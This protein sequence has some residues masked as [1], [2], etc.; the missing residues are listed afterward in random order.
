MRHAAVAAIA[1]IALTSP[2]LAAETPVTSAIEQVTVYPDG[3]SVTRI[4]R[5]DLAAGDNTLLARD[6]PPTLDPASVR[7]E[8]QGGARIVIGAVE[9]R[10]PRSDRPATNPEI[11]R[12][13]EALRD[14]RGV[15]DDGIAAAHAR[16]KFA[17]RFADAVPAGL[18]E[19][20]EARP[21]SEWRAAFAAVADEVAGADAIVREARL[22]QRTLDR[23]I[24]RLEAER[25]ANPPRKMEVRIDLASEAAAAAT[26]RVTYAVRGARWNPIYDARLDTGAPERKPSLELI[27]RAEIV[28]NTGEDWN[29]IAL[30]VSTTRTARAGNAPELAP[31]IVRFPDPPRPLAATRF[32]ERSRLRNLDAV[33][34]APPVAGGAAP[35]ADAPAKEREAEV[36]AHG[37]QALFRVPGAVT[38]ATN[39]GAKSL[40]I[41][42]ARVAP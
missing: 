31:L 40:R 17:E 16:R 12:R 18:G 41:A 22:R 11:E 20:G 39:E 35:A 2:G 14:E 30:A 27:R 38:V 5:A 4:I 15:L 6:F 33:A 10:L 23:D 25:R 1:L 8:G 34:P 13:L 42:S 24:A 28:Q 21:L 9:A 36:E 7:V 19:K 37:F 26:L 32:D 29:D 3:A